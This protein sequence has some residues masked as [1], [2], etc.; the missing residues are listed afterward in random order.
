[1]RDMSELSDTRAMPADPVQLFS[2]VF[3]R[4]RQRLRNW[5]RRSIADREEV[6]DILQDVFVELFQAFRLLQPIEDVGAWLFRV[7]RN[8]VTDLFRRKKPEAF[9]VL[10]GDASQAGE[11]AGVGSGAV[12]FADLLPAA[13]AGPEADYARLLLVEELVDAFEDLTADQRAV[14]YAH[15]IEG[16]SFK[17]ISAR[18]GL[19]VGTLL[20]RKHHAV[21]QLR[22]R[23]QAV[24]DDYRS[25]D[26]RDSDSEER[27]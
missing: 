11:G 10:P 3:G 20:S 6:E 23:L 16:L 27:T 13:D 26:D 15:E 17:E 7:A 4:E 8:R 18:T 22:R 14:F 21:L 12:D 19:P 1:M 2:T 5:L 24:Y 9:A 25:S